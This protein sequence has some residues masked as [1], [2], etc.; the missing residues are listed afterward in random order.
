MANG[1]TGGVPNAYSLEFN[2]VGLV[3]V[4]WMWS[5]IDFN[6]CGEMKLSVWMWWL[7]VKNKGFRT[8]GVEGMG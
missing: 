4:V 6:V 2:D 8:E 5:F 3:V 1:G 7:R